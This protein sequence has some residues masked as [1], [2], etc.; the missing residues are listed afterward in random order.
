MSERGFTEIYSSA[1]WSFF[2]LRA[3]I[4]TLA[5]LWARSLPR[6]LPMPVEP[7]VRRTVC[8]NKLAEL[9][10]IGVVN[11]PPTLPSTGKWFFL[12]KKPMMSRESTARNTSKTIEAQNKPKAME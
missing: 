7:P 6:P 5:P 2:M 8:D 11:S 10:E 9:S 12:E 3:T 4:M 1:A